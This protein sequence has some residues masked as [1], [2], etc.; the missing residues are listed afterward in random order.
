MIIDQATTNSS[1]ASS[2]S[3]KKTKS[4]PSKSFLLRADL[5]LFNIHQLNVEHEIAIRWDVGGGAD[6]AVGHVAWDDESAHATDLH[7]R[8][9]LCPTADDLVEAE[10]DGLAKV[11]AALEDDAIFTQCTSIVCG[12]GCASW[13][14][15]T[16]ARD[17]VDGLQ[18]VDLSDRCK[19]G[20]FG[21]F[22]LCH[23][24]IIPLCVFRR[25]TQLSGGMAVLGGVRS[26]TMICCSCG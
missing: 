25:A 6:G 26:T 9:T 10:G 13:Y 21:S 18:C 4:S 12:D 23:G 14:L 8:H 17:N 3:T 1:N 24:S 20:E 7:A 11:V 2:K 16:S 15:G 22:V 19:V 5:L